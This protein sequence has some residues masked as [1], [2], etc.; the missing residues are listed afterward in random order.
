[1]NA[2]LPVLGRGIYPLNEAARLAQLDGRMAARWASG[3]TFKKNGQ[4]RQSKGLIEF[5]MQPIGRHRDVTFAEMLTLRMVRTFRERGLA[6]QT[7][8]RVA[9]RAA[10]AFA[11]STPF[12][13]CRFRTDGRKIFMELNHDAAANDEPKLRA[14][15]R[16]LIDML[17]GQEV[18]HSIVEPSLFANVDF[19]D[20]GGIA[21]RWWPMGRSSPVVVDPAVLFGAPRISETRVSTAAINEAV[22]AEGGGESAVIAVANWYEIP[23]E[24]VR[25]AVKFETE[26]LARAA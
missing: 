23:H 26:W 16:R 5:E 11:T 7:I 17:S 8:K 20:V 13:T 14:R 19:D 24:S 9:E 1:M 25:E 12:A 21:S 15:E 22:C 18:F 4:R 2:V 10:A 6:L 3:N